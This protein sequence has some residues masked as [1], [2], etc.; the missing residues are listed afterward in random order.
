MSAT[1]QERIKQLVAILNDHSY[2]YYVLSQPSISDAEYD[3]LFRELE[4]LERA[5]PE[6]VSNESPTRR[7][8]ASP[9][10]E[11]QSV[12][13]RLPMLSLR[14]AMNE[15]ELVEFDSQVTRFLGD[16]ASKVEYTV[17]HKFDGV[18]VSLLYEKG[19]LTVGATRG[20]GYTGE[21]IT[22]NIRTVRSVPL[23]LRG[24]CPAVVE[25][26]G[27]VLFLRE[28]FQRLNAL[29]VEKGEEAFANPRNAA[30]G[31]LRQLDPQI[32]AE[33]PLAFFAYSL[34]VVEGLE[35]PSTHFACMRLV[36]RLGFPISPTLS[37]C[38]GKEDLVAAYTSHQRARAQL[39]FEVDGMVVKVNDL[40]LQQRL[41][42]RQRSPRWAVAAKFEAMEATTKLLAIEVQVGR[43]GALTP[44]AHLAPAQVGGVTV[45]RATLHN[46]DEI[47]RKDIRIGDTVTVKRQGD[48][49]PAVVSV[50]T[51][52]RDG[53]E[54]EFVFPANCPEC[55][56]LI[57]RNEGEAAHRCPNPHCP[58]R[59]EQRIL[60]F[61][62]RTGMDIEG[63][64]DKLVA[65]LLEHEVIRDIPGL[66]HL[67]PEAL[68][69]LP[70]MGEL[71]AKNIIEAI[72]RSKEKPLDR[73]LYALG[74]RHVGERT[75]LLIA[76][77]CGSL[78]RFLCLTEA[79]LL[80]IAEIGPETASAVTDFL[81]D[82]REQA[83]VRDLLAAGVVVTDV[84]APAG[85]ALTGKVFV[86]TGALATMSR[87]E[88]ERYIDERGGK[89][90]SSVSKK[91]NYVIAGADAG[92]K[93][94]KARE[95][96]ITV[97]DETEFRELLGL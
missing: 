41:G 27:E 9:S 33:R 34:G 47:R 91:T 65:L 10:K 13:H 49:I 30:S 61:A 4:A 39:P 79:Q 48:V 40:T 96:D 95:L 19:S 53:S 57:L 69:A 67:T 43:S 3:A 72:E 35:L 86:L 28:A 45:T 75:A 15:E 24:A 14:N 42:F 11:F 92:S 44:V 50:M 88:A 80:A 78:E 46:E 6:F 18:A 94:K 63:L 7:V 84:E 17:E 2:R 23:S 77:F 52:L 20:D 62:S 81:A 93:L 12:Q 1:E 74:I 8:G 64:G 38:R 32:T 51:H 89:A 66:Y 29:R 21:D 68:A 90:S 60:H 54:R 31:T 59:L 16:P 22:A 73:F 71:S 70:R 85:G 37:I 36:E 25:V 55:G 97:L 58:A 83:M 87:E 76:R 56:H 26:R 5:F 82:P